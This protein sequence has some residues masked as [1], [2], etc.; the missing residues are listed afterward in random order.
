MGMIMRRMAKAKK[1]HGAVAIEFAVLFMIFFTIVYAIIAYSVPL[2]LTL[3]FKQISADAARSAVRVSP[4]L[5]TTEEYIAR[6]NR[7]VHEVVEAS[8][9]PSDW[10]EGGCPAPGAEPGWI[11]LTSMGGKS[12]GHY[13]EV[14]PEPFRLPRYHLNICLQ[15]KYDKENAIIP[16]LTVFGVDIP[17]LPRDEDGNTTLRSRSTIRL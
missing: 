17:S 10:V 1:Q 8:W 11:A 13:I 15:R 7:Q 4:G 2:L 3:S 9:L 16:I 12:L 5:P 14:R 6:I